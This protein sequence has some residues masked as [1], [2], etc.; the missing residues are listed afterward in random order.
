MTDDTDDDDDG[1]KS[2][3][4]RLRSNQNLKPF[5]SGAEWK[6]NA[7]GRTPRHVQQNELMNKIGDS[8]ERALKVVDDIMMKARV[9]PGD[10]IKLRAANS[11]LDRLL[12]K[13][14]Q[15]VSASVTQRTVAADGTI[16][17]GSVSGG[18][19]MSPLLQAAQAH[20]AQEEVRRLDPPASQDTV[21]RRDDETGRFA[22]AA[23][24]VTLMSPSP[25]VQG[26][27]EPP[28]SA[29]SSS[30]PDRQS[31]A[32]ASA[33]VAEDPAAREKRLAELRKR[34]PG[35]QLPREVAFGEPDP[36]G[37]SIQGPLETVTLTRGSGKS[38]ERV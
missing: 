38:I 5:K 1:N 27:E 3:P 30:A 22:K 10:E 18:G 20:L 11:I 17:E 23:P 13:A 33:T 15:S 8:A 31:A 24:S 21:T 32:P 35:G 7:K 28:R 29:P 36:P 14:P 26:Q 16:I 25:S 9:S 37:Q 4:G 2:S 19:M 6:G 34:Y 12:G